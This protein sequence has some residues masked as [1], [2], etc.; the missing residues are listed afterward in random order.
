MIHTSLKAHLLKRSTTHETL[1]TRWAAFPITEA[2]LERHALWV[3]LA[4]GEVTE[5]MKQTDVPHGAYGGPAVAPEEWGQVL[6]LP[7]QLA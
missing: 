7:G 4:E 2:A 5:D 6:D 1:K 3:C